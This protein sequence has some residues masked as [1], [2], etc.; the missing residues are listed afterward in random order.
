MTEK[1]WGIESKSEWGFSQDVD[2]PDTVVVST[3]EEYKVVVVVKVSPVTVDLDEGG[4][5]TLSDGRKGD[6]TREA[7]TP[8]PLPHTQRRQYKI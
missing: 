1:D 7:V 5:S 3:R 4:P 6:G 2:P 8:R